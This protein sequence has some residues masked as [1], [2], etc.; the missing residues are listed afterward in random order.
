M[1]KLMTY[2]MMNVALNFDCINNSFKLL[3]FINLCTLRYRSTWSYIVLNRA[4][5]SLLLCAVL[6]VEQELLKRKIL[7]ACLDYDYLQHPLSS[8]LKLN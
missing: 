3:T 5:I 7:Q 6:V 8:Y 4:F 1:F 2:Y